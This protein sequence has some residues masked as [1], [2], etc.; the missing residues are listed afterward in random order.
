MQ[1]FFVYHSEHDFKLLIDLPLEQVILIAELLLATLVV[2][3]QHTSNE[4]VDQL[5]IQAC[6]AKSFA[7]EQHSS[8]RK[9]ADVVE[10]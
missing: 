3:Q 7:P 10:H 6:C 5:Y 8:C 2:F 9:Y 1:N 4:N